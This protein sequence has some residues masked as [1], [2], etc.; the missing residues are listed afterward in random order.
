MKMINLIRII[1]PAYFATICTFTHCPKSKTLEVT[2]LSKLSYALSITKFD[3]VYLGNAKPH[4]DKKKWSRF[5]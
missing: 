1:K 3:D 2:R 4:G 5:V